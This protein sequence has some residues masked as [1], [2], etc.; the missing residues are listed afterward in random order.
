[1]SRFMPPF[2]ISYDDRHN[3]P[4]ISGPW[5]EEE[6]RSHRLPDDAD[7]EFFEDL[8]ENG[9]AEWMGEA[10]E[11]HSVETLEEE[12]REQLTTIDKIRK[13]EKLP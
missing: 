9:Y 5:S 7:D 2:Y 11:L 12:I 10:Y 1:M 13:G 8:F 4:Y 6:L 3:R